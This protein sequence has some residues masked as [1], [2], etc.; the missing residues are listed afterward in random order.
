VT[1]VAQSAC[2]RDIKGIRAV[3]FFIEF[4][5]V[6]PPVDTILDFRTTYRSEHFPLKYEQLVLLPFGQHQHP[7][8][9]DCSDQGL[10][11]GEFCQ[12]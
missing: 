2:I 9:T 6:P 1:S 3:K 5:V 11:N 4:I 12:A 7:R 10:V 8:F